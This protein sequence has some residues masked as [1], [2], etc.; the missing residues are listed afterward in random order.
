MYSTSNMN[1][2]STA[3]D[4][5]PFTIAIAAD[6]LDDLK[7][8]ISRARIPP[9]IHGT[10]WTEG[11]DVDALRALLAHWHDFDWRSAE[12]AINRVPA[13]RADIDGHDIHFVHVRG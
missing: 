4:A 11:M 5:R 3:F 6:V 13:F 8:R 2:R 7:N 1:H 9:V 12:A 10:G